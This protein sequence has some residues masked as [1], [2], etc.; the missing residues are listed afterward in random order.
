M[1]YVITYIGVEGDRKKG[2]GVEK[3]SKCADVIH[4]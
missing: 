1:Y 3:F 2:R 4:G